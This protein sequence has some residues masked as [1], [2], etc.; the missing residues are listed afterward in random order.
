MPQDRAVLGQRIIVRS[1][2]W[3]CFQY[4]VKLREYGAVVHQTSPLEAAHASE[5]SRD[6]SE[7]HFEPHVFI[8]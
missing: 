3:G 8:T 6:M 5:T 4:L 2:V 1:R 7:D